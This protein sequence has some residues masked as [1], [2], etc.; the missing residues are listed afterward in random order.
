MNTQQFLKSLPKKG[1]LYN[2][3]C[4]SRS[5]LSHVSSV[6][7]SVVLKALVEHK[8]M[9]FADL[10]RQVEG[11]SE[12]MLSQTLRHLVRDGLVARKS[13]PVIPPKVEYSLT[14]FGRDCTEHI[15]SVC[16]FVEK[17]M[18]KVVKNQFKY[19]EAPAEVSWQ[20]SS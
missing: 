18:A 17:H 11:I 14:P 2:A 3:L 20:K 7:G 4:P 8:T 19:D 6:W 10:R 13:Y 12:K 1:D 15:L 16:D 5:I 9:R